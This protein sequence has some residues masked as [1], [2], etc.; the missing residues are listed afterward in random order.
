MNID[1]VKVASC[2][3]DDWPLLFGVRSLGKKTV[4]STAGA[5]IDHLKKVFWRLIPLFYILI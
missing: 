4:I 1:V 3:V 5:S 2:S